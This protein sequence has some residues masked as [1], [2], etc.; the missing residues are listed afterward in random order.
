MIKKIFIIFYFF[1]ISNKL[2]ASDVSDFLKSLDAINNVMPSRTELVSSLFTSL[3]AEQVSAQYFSNKI[4]CK[5]NNKNG[6]AGPIAFADTPANRQSINDKTQNYI[7]LF[8]DSMTHWLAMDPIT[9]TYTVNIDPRIYYG[10]MWDN[11]NFNAL[12]GTTSRN[13]RDHFDRCGEE[14]PNIF[15]PETY[16]H[17]HIQLENNYSVILYGGNDILIYQPILQAIPWLVYFRINAVVNNLNRIVTY[18]QAQGAK[19]ILISHTPRPEIP[20]HNFFGDFGDADVFFRK[21]FEYTASAI[22]TAISV[23]QDGMHNVIDCIN[24]QMCNPHRTIDEIKSASI[25]SSGRDRAVENFIA[26]TMYMEGSHRTDRTWLSQQ[27]G[28]L[29][30]SVANLVVLSRNT[31]YINEWFMFSDPGALAAGRWWAGNPSLYRGDAIHFV[32]PFGQALHTSN[33]KNKIVSLGWNSNPT[34]S[35]GDRC[36]AVAGATFPTGQPAGFTAE[37][38]DL[39]EVTDSDMNLILL[40]FI[41]HICHL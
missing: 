29:T 40:C 5:C 37:P 38:P 36:N 19:V 27:L 28:Y 11:I 12:G 14:K 15:Y 10:L 35:Y 6:S 2:S 31:E 18:H 32:H 30:L 8:G 22:G 39:P 13:L 9:P 16:E 21:M 20:L 23:S 17:T 24:I 33:I 41:F 3:T 25:Y 7:N 1:I 4:G 34:P 26:A